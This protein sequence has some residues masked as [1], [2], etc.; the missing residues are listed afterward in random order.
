MVTEK[1]IRYQGSESGRRGEEKGLHR[2]HRGRRDRREKE[3]RREEEEERRGGDAR[4]SE[5]TLRWK[6]RR[7]GHPQVR[8]RRGV[9]RANPRP[10]YKTGTWGTRQESEGKAVK[11]YKSEE[12]E[13]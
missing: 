4:S 1:D 12:V 5:P 7:M 8:F 9:N 11:E 6:T 2:V 13:E 10:R 3:R